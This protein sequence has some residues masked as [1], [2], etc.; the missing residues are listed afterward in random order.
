MYLC[1]VVEQ[2]LNHI[3]QHRLC[4]KEDKI[5]LAVSGGIDSMVMLD[6]FLSAGYT[7]G[8]AHCNFQ[9][10][11]L[12]SERD[13]YFVKEVCQIRG[14]PFYVS[15]F[16]TIE[17][18]SSNNLSIQLAARELRYAWFNE[19][20]EKEKYN[21]L[22]TAHHLNDSIETVLLNWVH[23]GAIEGLLGIPVKNSPVIRPLLFASRKMIEAY[24]AEK[25]LIWREDAS[26]QTDDYPR[27]FLRHQVVP[28]LQALN[29]ALEETFRQ[30]LEK[31]KAGLALQRL[32]VDQLTREFF[33]D[34]PPRVIIRKE[35]FQKISDPL[36]L[37][38]LL[39]NYHFTPA[40]C[41]DMVQA[42]SSQPGKQFFSPTHRLVMDRSTLIIT[43][44]ENFWNPVEIT[45]AQTSAALGP[46]DMAIT[47]F[48]G[49][50]IPADPDIAVLDKDLL[51]FPLVWRPWKPG[52]F[53]YPLGME[54]RKKVSDFLIDSK[55]PMSDKPHVTVLESAGQII[56]VAGYRIDNRFKVT[57]ATK[58]ALQF[59]LHPHFV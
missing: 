19:L 16:N 9:L 21:H 33:T 35:L 32:A 26:N 2:F 45:P 6:L 34:D 22:A 36:M 13:E 18:A 56:W 39:R 17:Y 25:K 59:T 20:L 42:I 3:E 10:R 44:H 30:G 11:G 37:W 1:S 29:P 51:E 48:S 52:D 8:V 54:H 41:E 15:R 14:I 28:K 49:R 7:L 47:V 53:F 55:V 40:V 27:N 4:R 5:L 12:D 50:D 38:Y 57:P 23:G 24:A 58:Q 31:L 46:W 43:P